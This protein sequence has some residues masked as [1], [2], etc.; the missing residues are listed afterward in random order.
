M[1]D[2]QGKRIFIVED[3]VTN[4]AVFVVSLKRS[5]AVVIQDPWNSQ[6]IDLLTRYMPI[7]VI[8]LDLMLRRGENG[9]DIYDRI[10]ERPD[11]AH[12]PIV[13]V[14]AADPDIEIPRARAKGFAGFIAKP[15]SLLDFPEQVATCISGQQVWVASHAY[16]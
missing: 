13:A 15:I 7:D 5:G 11:L 1:S 14:S 2:L 12:I 8:L 4:M 9:Y 10:K 3:D 16:Y 6:T